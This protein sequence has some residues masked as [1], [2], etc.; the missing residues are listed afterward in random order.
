VAS[1]KLK[2]QELGRAGNAQAAEAILG[3][4]LEL[5]P[6]DAE[7]LALQRSS[8]ARAAGTRLRFG[9]A[10]GCTVDTLAFTADLREPGAVHSPPLQQRER[11]RVLRKSL[12]V[13]ALQEPSPRAGELPRKPYDVVVLCSGPATEASASRCFVRQRAG[14]GR[15][16]KLGMAGS[17]RDKVRESLQRAQSDLWSRQRGRRADRA[18]LLAGRI[19]REA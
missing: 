12:P 13:R 6:D 17:A 18:V 5:Q 8:T 1:L 11:A 2:A 7:A 14:T 4:V 10:C 3:R 16:L 9:A 19:A 15:I